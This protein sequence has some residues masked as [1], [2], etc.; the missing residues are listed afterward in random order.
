MSKQLKKAWVSQKDNLDLYTLSL[1]S[2]D[3]EGPN[4]LNVRQLTFPEAGPK[5]HI[6]AIGLL[7]EEDLFEL[8]ITLQ[9]IL[10]GC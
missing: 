8:Y 2:R 10:Y 1:E 4:R 6:M 7:T 3:P 9:E 5:R